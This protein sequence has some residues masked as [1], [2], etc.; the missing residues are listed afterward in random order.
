[1]KMRVAEHLQQTKLKNIFLEKSETMCLAV[2][3]DGVIPIRKRLAT[4][5]DERW[6]RQVGAPRKSGTAGHEHRFSCIPHIHLFFWPRICFRVWSA[7]IITEWPL[8]LLTLA[9][10]GAAGLAWDFLD[11]QS[12]SG[13]SVKV[14][15][16]S[17]DGIAPL[18]GHVDLEWRPEGPKDWD[19]KT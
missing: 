10:F 16:R 12:R 1:M 5:W 3:P 6:V 2:G 13:G 15:R 18:T 4:R 8:T 7:Y 19:Q 11:V 9:E 17:D 14:R